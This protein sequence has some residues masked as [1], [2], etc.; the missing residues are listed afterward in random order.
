MNIYVIYTSL[1]KCWLLQCIRREKRKPMFACLMLCE[2]LRIAPAFGQP[3]YIFNDTRQ[4]GR[5]RSSNKQQC[6]SEHRVLKHLYQHC[7]SRHHWPLV[8]RISRLKRLKWVCSRKAAIS[9]KSSLVTVLLG[10]GGTLGIKRSGYSSRQKLRISWTA[11]LLA[12]LLTFRSAFTPTQRH[13][14]CNSSGTSCIT[15]TIDLEIIGVILTL[16]VRSNVLSNSSVDRGWSC[17]KRVGDHTLHVVKVH[18]RARTGYEN[19]DSRTYSCG[20]VRSL[21]SRL[22]RHHS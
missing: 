12:V 18:V 3:V 4:T 16:Y 11:S 2:L 1:K 5:Q 19:G 8:T 6:R 21:G 15:S 22:V 9:S 13:T 20:P 10:R 17:G 7:F 14:R